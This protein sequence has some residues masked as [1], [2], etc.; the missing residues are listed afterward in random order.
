MSLT[1]NSEQV[2]AVALAYV[3]IWDQSEG[4]EISKLPNMFS[5]CTW[6]DV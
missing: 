3:F 5:F 2:R 1:Q 6:K 4:W